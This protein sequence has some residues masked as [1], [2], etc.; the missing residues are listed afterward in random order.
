[1]A[2]CIHWLMKVRNQI[3]RS[4]PDTGPLF[5]KS[6]AE[7]KRAKELGRLAVGFNLQDSLVLDG[8]VDMVRGFYELGVRQMVLAYNSRN[9]IGDGC[10]E[11]TDSGLSRFGVEVVKEMSDVGMLID[12]SHTGYKTCM[13]AM[14]ITEA[15]FIFS[16]TACAAVSEH[17]RNISDEQIRACASTGGIIGVAGI[18]AFLGDIE[19][20]PET[21][22]K[23]IDHIAALVGP[24]YVSIGNDYVRN[25]EEIWKWARSNPKAW[26]DE[27][28]KVILEGKCT[29][30]EDLG[31]LVDLMLEH[32]YR[33]PE[34]KG[35][36]GENFLRVAQS[37]WK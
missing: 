9:L 4:E 12:G 14:Q 16:H 28:G 30:P 17:Y 5:V 3:E 6:V 7:I 35:I 19:A 27:G 15:P 2:E 23:H 26:P 22:F 36:L 8:S 21:Q 34:I 11:R 29:Q 10:T 13:D 31:R 20:K 37:V 18:G 32:G 33:E 1:M 24:Q 25:L